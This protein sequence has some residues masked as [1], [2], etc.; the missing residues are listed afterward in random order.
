M[1]SYADE[2][3]LR[4]CHFIDYKSCIS[5]LCRGFNLNRDIQKNEKECSER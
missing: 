5:F 3:V 4:R 2:H 1:V